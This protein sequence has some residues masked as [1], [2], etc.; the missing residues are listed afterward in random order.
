[1]NFLCVF[2]ATTQCLRS[3]PDNAT[4]S[5]SLCDNVSLFC[6]CRLEVQ[7]TEP[8]SELTVFNVAPPAPRANK[9]Q[10][11]GEAMRASDGGLP[12]ELQRIAYEELGETDQGRVDALARLNQ[13]LDEDPELNARRDNVFLLR[14]IRMR[15]YNIEAAL[16]TLKC[17]Y[18]NRAAYPCIYDN[19][20]PSNVKPASR[21]LVLVLPNPDVH[22]RRVLLL[23]SGSWIPSLATHSEAQQ[24]FHLALEFLAAD[25]SSQTVGIS[26]LVDF[27]GLS[28]RKLLSVNI[29]ERTKRRKEQGRTAAVIHRLRTHSAMI[30]VRRHYMGRPTPDWGSP[31]ERKT[32]LHGSKETK[33][34]TLKAILTFLEET[35]PFQI[36]MAVRSGPP[37]SLASSAASASSHHS[38]PPT[39]G[40][41]CCPALV[42]LHPLP[43]AGWREAQCVCVGVVKEGAKWFCLFSPFWGPSPAEESVPRTS[44]CRF[45]FEISLAS[46]FLG[47]ALLSACPFLL[48]FV[49]QSKL[50]RL[51]T[52][53]GPRLVNSPHGAIARSGLLGDRT[54]D[55]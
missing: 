54:P 1:M 37:T 31:A 36:S 53:L 18:K 9:L 38:L 35:V 52:P 26:V 41:A 27:E 24:A 16:A 23:R 44:R 21:G 4:P 34:R 5:L 14:Y 15:K 13:L 2:G 45:A 8:P 7:P 49:Q 12:A 43:I 32:K 39:T 19:F 51:K 28:M 6:L 55:Q 50:V 22:G 29:A 47:N 40:D 11:G 30:P 3:S 42:V 46:L 10:V 17:Y 33:G 48:L 20:V 25:P